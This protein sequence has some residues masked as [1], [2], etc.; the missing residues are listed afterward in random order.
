M[1]RGNTRPVVRR[2]TLDLRASIHNRFDVEV[3]DSVTGELKQ[4]GRAFNVICNTYWT[5]L[6]ANSDGVWSP[7][8]NFD[9][10]LFGSGSG[11]PAAS[12]T[13]LFTL[14]GYKSFS[15]GFVPVT[16]DRRTG[17][18]YRQVVVTLNA[19]EYVGASITELGIGYDASHCVTHA[20][21]Q[22]MEGNPISIQKT[23]TD[24]IQIY[25][26]LY[27]HWPN[28]GWYGG[29]VNFLD[30]SDSN[31]PTMARMLLG[32]PGSN[33]IPDFYPGKRAGDSPGG[34]FPE[35]RALR[36]NSANKTIRMTA[37]F[38]ASE[39]NAPIRYLAIGVYAQYTGVTRACLQLALGSWFSPPQITGEAVGTGDGSKT[40]F[41]SAFPVRSGAKVYVDGVEVSGVTVRG[42]P[43]DAA[44]MERW[45]NFLAAG[46]A[47]VGAMSEA[48][49]PLY[50]PA[51]SPGTIDSD[52]GIYLD[53]LGPG[54]FMYP[55]ENPFYTL[56]LSKIRYCCYSHNAVLGIWDSN[57]CINWTKI[58]E[59]N[60][61]YTG[62]TVYADL[63][64][65]SPLSTKKY[66]RFSNEGSASL[67][68]MFHFVADVADTAS[69][70]IFDTAPA[71]GSVITMD[72]VPDCI[73]KD[74]NHVFD[75][76]V[77]LTVG[78]YQEA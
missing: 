46:W 63:V 35:S 1:T 74:S 34:H 8:S 21:L 17:V 50:Y 73:A 36:V 62:S 54:Y 76:D 51:F 72:Y 20:M 28:G 27:L 66:L 44:T 24:V 39:A 14:V 67:T 70:I 31:I 16:I 68:I 12:D 43:A 19:E 9:Y 65:P 47:S 25:A 58:A 42:G 77:T 56:G 75:M 55:F 53:A 32:G 10:V 69:N 64:L 57:D 40:G 18:A 78:E 22:D 26:T 6:F 2:Q 33:I 29:S 41:A 30:Y 15:Q 45:F 23:D 49:T 5:R 3:R 13:A 38:A 60:P 7:L 52:K 61:S 4:K 11:T 59:L 37:R 48:G 71:A